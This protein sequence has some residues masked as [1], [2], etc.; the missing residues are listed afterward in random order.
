MVEGGCV[1]PNADEVVLDWMKLNPIFVGVVVFEE[2]PNWN[3]LVVG[4]VD[5]VEEFVAV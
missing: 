3:R 1:E 2:E 5:K 4:A